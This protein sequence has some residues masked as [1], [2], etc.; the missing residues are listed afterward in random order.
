MLLLVVLSMLT[1]SPAIAF[2]LCMSFGLVRGLAVLTG[3]RLTDPEALR[4]F[5]RRFEPLGPASRTA[6][7][8]TEAALLVLALLTLPMPGAVVVVLCVVL[9]AIGV[10]AGAVPRIRHDHELRDA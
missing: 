3:R 8:I 6:M 7:L 10:Y 2:A 9:I 4:T 1:G 5:H